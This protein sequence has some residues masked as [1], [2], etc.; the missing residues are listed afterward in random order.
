M[1][2]EEIPTPEKATEKLLGNIKALFDELIQLDLA[3]ALLPKNI[4][5]FARTILTDASESIQSL[6]RRAL[7]AEKRAES[8]HRSWMG[9]LREIERLKIVAAASDTASEDFEL[10]Q[11]VKELRDK[12]LKLASSVSFDAFSLRAQEARDFLLRTK[13]AH[14]PE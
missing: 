12:L 14:Q 6:E 9:A 7:A 13:P 8:K 1:K 3:G 2:P 4:G 11:Q 10:R 5:N